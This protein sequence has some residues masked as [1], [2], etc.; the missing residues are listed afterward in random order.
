MKWQFTDYVNRK[1][2]NLLFGKK[3][4]KQEKQEPFDKMGNKKTDQNE[5][6]YCFI[7]CD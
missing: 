2:I 5:I 7:M 3:T 4:E 6:T 1:G